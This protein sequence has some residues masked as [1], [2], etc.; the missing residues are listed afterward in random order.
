MEKLSVRLRTL[1]KKFRA[2]K[3]RTIEI[4]DSEM[5]MKAVKKAGAPVINCNL[6]IVK[7]AS[8][9][10]AASASA[11]GQLMVRK[12]SIPSLHADSVL[13]AQAVTPHTLRATRVGHF[14]L[15]HPKKLTV[16]VLAEGSIINDGDVIGF[17][18]S[19]NNR[20]EVR[21]DMGGVIGATLVED[22]EAVEYGQPLARFDESVSAKVKE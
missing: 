3:F 5:S 19:M 21:A 20:Y 11:D 15:T 18:E 14:Y 6:P 22:G 2:T 10:N 4:D 1:F 8:S 12:P 9:Q 17:I 13:E 7:S 16:A